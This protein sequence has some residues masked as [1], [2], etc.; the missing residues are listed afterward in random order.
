M[1]KS[2]A[3]LL[4]IVLQLYALSSILADDQVRQVQEA[5]RKRHLF[6]GNPNGEMSPALSAAVGRYQE[7]K[8]FPRTGSIDVETAV[9]LGIVRPV[10]QVAETPFVVEDNGALRGANGESLADALLWPADKYPVRF[11]LTSVDST[12]VGPILAA[13][14]TELKP[15]V[16]NRPKAA[17][18]RPRVRAA[19]AQKEANPFVLAFRSVDHFL[20][21][22]KDP[23]KKRATAKRL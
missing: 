15:L 12:N 22:D 18:S 21:G 1:G 19:R 4:S 6:Y 8:G 14:D 9:S 11:G 5:L 7:K 23:K 2:V 17:P 10:P 16:L 3:S 13:T 20:F